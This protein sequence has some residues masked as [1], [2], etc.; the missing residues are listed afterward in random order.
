M[1]LP[2]R[3]QLQ[4]NN[5]G[6]LKTLA[7]QLKLSGLGDKEQIIDRIIDSDPIV[8]STELD[9]LPTDLL[10]EVLFSLPYNEVKEKCEYSK[11]IKNICHSPKFWHKYCEIRNFQKDRDSDTWEQTALLCTLGIWKVKNDVV[12]SNLIWDIT[13]IPLIGRLQLQVGEAAI[14]L[15]IEEYHRIVF[16]DTVRIGIPNYTEL[17]Y[18]D[19]KITMEP[20][21]MVGSTLEYVLKFVYSEMYGLDINQL[22]DIDSYVYSENLPAENYFDGF[23][24][25]ANTWYFRAK[26]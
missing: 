7:S 13:E 10:R 21:T 18:Q 4:E 9:R 23:Q 11:R 15:G 25:G 8:H 3:E 17:Q 24:R 26:E 5:L 14:P 16:R 19:P 12:L 22:V 2:S 1:E 6:E 20:D